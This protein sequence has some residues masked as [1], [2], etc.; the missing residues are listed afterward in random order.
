[1]SLLLQENRNREVEISDEYKI[2]YSTYL[3]KGLLLLFKKTNDEKRAELALEAN[4]RSISNL[5]M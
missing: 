2:K 5:S 4:R 3:L 1:M